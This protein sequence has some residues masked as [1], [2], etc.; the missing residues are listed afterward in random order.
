MGDALWQRAVVPPA[1]TLR[2]K[3]PQV[4]P[5]KSNYGPLLGAAGSD[6]ANVTRLSTARELDDRVLGLPHRL[7]HLPDWVLHGHLRQ[8]LLG[9]GDRDR[10]SYRG[11]DG[12]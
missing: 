1:P 4:A 10:D 12:P 11:G 8:P 6:G 5:A 7:M 2:G 9:R 3:L